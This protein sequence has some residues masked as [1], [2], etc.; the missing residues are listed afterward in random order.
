LPKSWRGNDFCV[1]IDYTEPQDIV[2]GFDGSGNEGKREDDTQARI[3]RV[4]YGYP[5]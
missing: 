4:G 3:D 5:F 2:D 1:C